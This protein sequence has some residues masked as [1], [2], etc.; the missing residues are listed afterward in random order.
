MN[1]R[2][3][4]S[5]SANDQLETSIYD[6]F[7][8]NPLIVTP[9]VNKPKKKTNRSKIK[10]KKAS[11][12]K[13]NQLIQA[14][15]DLFKLVHQTN[16][17]DEILEEELVHF[18]LA[19]LLKQVKNFEHTPTERLVIQY[20]VLRS[21]KNNLPWML[22]ADSKLLQLPTVHSILPALNELI[23]EPEQHLTTL[24]FIFLCLKLTPPRAEQDDGLPAEFDQNLF[25]IIDSYRAELERELSKTTLSLPTTTK[26]P[27]KP[28]T[29]IALITLSLF[30]TFFVG[31]Y[32]LQNYTDQALLNV[33]THN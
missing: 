15:Q 26:T 7:K 19:K 14:A 33:L 24:E 4:Q 10:A 6:S 20:F 23:A 3:E 29:K 27:L 13:H 16:Q 30:I 25:Q 22:A 12:N 28:A 18:E 32:C 8:E 2:T 31:F 1:N 9:A 17:H 11:V 21:I 5:W